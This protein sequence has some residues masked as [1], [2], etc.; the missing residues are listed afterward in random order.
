[1]ADLTTDAN[2]LAFSVFPTLLLVITLFRL[3]LNVTG[4][5]SI[6]LHGYAGQ[7]IEAFGN[8]VVGGNYAVGIVVFAILFAVALGMIG[9]KGKPIILLCE[10]VT[11]TMFSLTRIVMRFAPVGV[12]AAIAYT[13]GHGGLRVLINLAWLVG[14]LYGALIFFI[15]VVLLPIGIALTRVVNFIN[16]ELPGKLCNPDRPYC[17]LFPKYPDGPRYPSQIFEAILDIVTLPF[18]LLFALLGGAEFEFRRFSRPR[19]S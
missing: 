7:V 15:L 5:R 9:E 3:S 6:L 19:R 2:A 10:S 14:T 17:V 12:G 4:T 8:V 1:V 18:R 16:D 13:V 11:E